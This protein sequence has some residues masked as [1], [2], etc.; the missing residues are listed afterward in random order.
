MDDPRTKARAFLQSTPIVSE[1]ED[2]LNRLIYE[3][4]DDLHGYLVSDQEMAW[5]DQRVLFVS[6]ESFSRSKS[7]TQNFDADSETIDWTGW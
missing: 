3:K 1:L 2:L 7:T 6:G 4:P 5:I